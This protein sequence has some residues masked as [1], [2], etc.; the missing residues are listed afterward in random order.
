MASQLGSVTGNKRLRPNQ[1]ADLNARLSYLPQ[2]LAAESQ[3]EFQKA[4]ISNMEETNKIN[5]SKLGL[6]TQRLGLENQ[7][8]GLSEK[9]FGLQ[10]K[11]F[12]LSEQEL[13]L[14]TKAAEFNQK[15]TQKGLDLKKKSEAMSAG[16]GAAGL[17][18]NLL[19]GTGLKG[20]LGD[21]INS[22]SKTF[23]GTGNTI[24]PGG[25]W[26]V[27]VGA[28]IAGGLMGFGAS[29]LV[30][31]KNKFAKFGVGAGVGALTGFFGGGNNAIGGAMGG[32]LLGGLGSLF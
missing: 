24:T 8:F 14:Q 10:E 9:Q 26:D 18:F 7:Q 32:G 19:Q 4:Q 17:G 15:A 11:Q 12:G 21:S 31:T 6:D 3:E 23:G 5:Q 13:G 22:V 25:F 16:V 30:P 2:T 29:K 20:T 27:P 28:S 1:L